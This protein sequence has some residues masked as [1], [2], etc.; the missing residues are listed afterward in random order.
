MYL[1]T[2]YC[3]GAGFDGYGHSVEKCPV[4]FL[5]GVQGDGMETYVIIN[6]LPIT[7]EQAGRIDGRLRG[8]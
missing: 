7:D 3:L 2:Y 5:E 6:V 8:M 1:I 4:K